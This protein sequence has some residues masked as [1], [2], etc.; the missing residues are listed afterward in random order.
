MSQ[1]QNGGIRGD[2]LAG[3]RIQLDHSDA[4]P[5]GAEREPE[6]AVGVVEHGR[7]NGVEIVPFAGLDDHA[8]VG[9]VIGRVVG[10]QGGVCRQTDGGG[11]FAETGSRVVEEIP[12]AEVDNI[13]RPIRHAA[14]GRHGLSNPTGRIGEDTRPP[15]PFHQVFGM[16]RHHAAPREKNPELV[17]A[18]DN[19]GGVMHE[20]IPANGR[21]QRRRR[22]GIRGGRGGRRRGSK[23]RA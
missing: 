17:L 7:V 4:A 18:F 11:V 10:V 21:A 5:E 12:V 22:R 13:R 2:A 16:I 14:I 6:T 9:P 23:G 1:E 19:G 20:S 15:L 8:L 3:P